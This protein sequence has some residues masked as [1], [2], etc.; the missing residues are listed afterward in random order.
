MKKRHL[1]FRTAILVLLVTFVLPSFVLP[2]F[3]LP[4]GEGLDPVWCGFYC[5]KLWWGW[6][7]FDASAPVTRCCLASESGDTC[8]DWWSCPACSTSDGGGGGF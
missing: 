1:V 6:L 8:G 7:C 5:E 3:A 4:P 2:S